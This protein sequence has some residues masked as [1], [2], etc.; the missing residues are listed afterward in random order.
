M[1]PFPRIVFLMFLINTT[2]LQAQIR[3]GQNAVLTISDDTQFSCSADIINYGCIFNTGTINLWNNWIN[4]GEFISLAGTTNFIG[5]QLQ[6][7]NHNGYSFSNLGIDGAGIII[8]SDLSV[9]NILNLTHGHVSPLDGIQFRLAEN[10][11]VE[12]A[13]EISYVKGRLIRE[14]IGDIFYPIGSPQ[15]FRPAWLHI[16]DER[17]QIA[18]LEVLEPN[19]ISAA[20]NGIA[21]VVQEAY[22]RLSA[23]EG[24]I[25]NTRISLSYSNTTTRYPNLLVVVELS[26]AGNSYLNLGHE[27]LD[28][29]NEVITSR[30]VISGNTFALAEIDGMITICNVISPNGD[31]INDYLYIANIEEFPDNEVMIFNRAGQ[32]IYQ[33]DNYHNTWDG[34]INN[35][36]LP[37]G[38][39][40]CVVKLLNSGQAYSQ[41]ITIVR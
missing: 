14:G 2:L 38:H 19:L 10:A 4:N 30:D 15:A 22:W 35:E 13:S 25:Q 20:Q 26:N 12:N 9:S 37:A 40:F 24:N 18:G 28:E 33:E 8:E 17:T 31:A 39:Y 7:V 29:I 16:S 21:R 32:Q 5:D 41:T 11:Q 23:N 34:S 27:S 6:H 36:P 3:I 1:N